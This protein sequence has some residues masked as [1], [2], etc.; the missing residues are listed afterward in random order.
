[1]ARLAIRM[2][3]MSMT[4][5]EGEVSSWMVKVG[6]T[7]TEGDVVAE[8][9]TDK[10]DMEVEATVAG[11]LVEIVHE[12]GTVEVGEPIGWVEGEEGGGGF[13][14][15]LSEPDPQPE[16]APEPVVERAPEPEPEPPAP[17]PVAD[18]SPSPA[19][20]PAA[21]P[22]ARG[23]ANE[24]GIDLTRVT[25]TGPEGLIRVDDVEAL[26]R[27]AAVAAPAARPAAQPA[28]AAAPVSGDRKA[29]IRAAVARKMTPSAEIPQFTVWREIELDAANA[30]R[31]GLS[32]TTVLL[33]A[34]AAALR[35][36]PDLLCRWE[37]D[38]ATEAGPPAVALAVATD[39]GLL[40][41]TFDEPDLADA[42][43]LDAEMRDVVRSAHTG[44][45]DRKYMGVANGS[46]SNLGGMGVDRFQ[47][48]LTPPQAS[49]LA[50]GSIRQRPVAVPGGV[51][52]ALTVQ[53][54]LTVDHRVADG[55]HA[56]Q[57]LRSFAA[58]LGGSL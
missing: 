29:A 23:L 35:D 46:L 10:V 12:S 21:V 49:V 3:K 54:G 6:D 41:P 11:T 31:R 53:A 37:D 47:A 44:K 57:L 20:P 45:L 13:G 2:P 42:H 33:R 4:M 15:L 19:G 1:M 43:E 27:P 40:V 18:E 38:R 58:R 32:W 7:I 26:I 48:L 9:M 14:D 24:H 5:T 50:L 39:R 52:L 17:E 55:A 51:G 25:G 28:A 36:V 22:R 16:P 56:A 30:G 34:Y 8:V